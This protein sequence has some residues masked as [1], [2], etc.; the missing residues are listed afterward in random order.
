[1]TQVG[2]P[3]CGVGQLSVPVAGQGPGPGGAPEPARCPACGHTAAA[4]LVGE[5]AWLLGEQSR[6][7]ARLTWVQGR[8]AAGDLAPPVAVPL[9][10]PGSP[11]FPGGPGLP[12]VP[13]VPGVPG[14]G[15]PGGPGVVPGGWPAPDRE[16]RP[17]ALQTLL[18]GLGA[19]LIVI[20]SV[21]FAAVAWDRL[22]PTGQVALLAVVVA[23]L[24]GGAHALRDRYR[25]TAE[26]LAAMA[27]AVAAVAFLAAPRLGLGTGWM[28]RETALWATLALLAVAGLSAGLDRLSRLV[29]WRAATVVAVTGA[30]GAFPF[31]LAGAGQVR[32]EPFGIAGVAAVAAVVLGLARSGLGSGAHGPGAHGP[33]DQGTRGRGSGDVITLR[34][35]GGCLAATS[36]IL[37]LAAYGHRSEHSWTLA[38]AAVAVAAWVAAARFGGAG[39][40][41]LAGVATAHVPALAVTGLRVGRPDLR[42]G[43]LAPALAGLALLGG[44][45]VAG[46][47]LRRADR[48][49][50]GVALRPAL[51]ATGIAGWV[52][53]PLLLDDGGWMDTAWWARYLALV[54]VL[55]LAVAVGLRVTW[56]AWAAGGTGSLAVAMI[57]IDADRGYRPESVTLPVAAVLLVAGLVAALW[58]H[59]GRRDSL[60]ALGPA[61]AM[62]VVPSA[63]AALDDVTSDGGPWRGVIV[64]GVGT[65]LVLAGVAVRLRGPLVVGLIGAAI[66]GV[67]QLYALADL[68]PRWVA[69]AFAG[70]LL[71]AVGFR[72][73]VLARA[74]RHALRRGLA[75]R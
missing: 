6:L 46:A 43:A 39:A 58:T 14:P 73:E 30:A 75:L 17:V 41:V 22:G 7:L 29:A 20:A 51:L 12:G 26:A 13:G 31:A 55:L 50:G 35:I 3:A 66:A 21:V 33:G 74:G 19:L 24:S 25:A 11:G 62:A 10:G 16:R 70:A 37:A 67:A 18:L 65:A 32:P 49:V 23:L 69:L 36:A 8:I 27:A 59:D 52:L 64:L 45:A 54:A 4:V 40:A 9:L 44:V 71:V 60:L 72:V 34:V 56:T 47:C 2:C 61:L 5:A 63:L 38:W 42:D 68:L 57:T 1:M 15:V 48:Q 28:R 53:A